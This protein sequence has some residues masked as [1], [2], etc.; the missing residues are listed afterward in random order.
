MRDSLDT[1]TDMTWEEVEEL[2]DEI[3][4]TRKFHET[5][6]PSPEVENFA[7]S[8]NW[9]FYRDGIHGRG[10]FNPNKTDLPF[11]ATTPGD[12]LASLAY[13]ECVSVEEIAAQFVEWREGC[14]K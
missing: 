5:R 10:W 12:F 8:L 14:C 2:A 7:N 4:A 6:I 11:E 3:G 9:Y 1:V 13:Y